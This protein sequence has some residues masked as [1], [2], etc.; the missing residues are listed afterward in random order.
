MHPV[1]IY[2]CAKDGEFEVQVQYGEDASGQMYVTSRRL[3][4]GRW[5]EREEDLRCPKCGDPL[6]RKA[7]DDLSDLG[8]DEPRRGG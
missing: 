5:F 6:T 2:E 8:L 3:P 4:P 7:E 1:T